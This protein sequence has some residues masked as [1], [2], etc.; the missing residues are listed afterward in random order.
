MVALFQEAYP[1]LYATLKDAVHSALI[2]LHSGGD[3][4]PDETLGAVAVFLGTPTAGIPAAEPQETKE[5]PSKGVDL[6]TESERTSA[7][8][9]SSRA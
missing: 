2:D 6:A 7:E 5:P 4:L 9:A 1:T 8:R 3:E